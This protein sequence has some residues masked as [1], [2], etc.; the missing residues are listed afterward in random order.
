[1]TRLRFA[2]ATTGHLH[3]ASARMALVSWLFARRHKADFSLWLDDLDPERTS[4]EYM[5]SIAHDL[6]WLGLSWDETIQQST[7]L[8]RYEQAAD[9]L[10][11]SGRLYPC[12]E[13][14]DELRFKREMRIKRGQAPVYDRAMLKLTPEQRA[15]AEANG[16]RPYWRFRLTDTT[17]VWADM[18]LGQQWVKLTAVSDPIMIRADGTPMHLFTSVVDDIEAGTTH[19]LRSADQ[20][21]ATGIQIDLFSALGVNP[22]RL[23]FGHLPALTDTDGEKPSRRFD[24]ITLRSLRADGIESEAVAAYLGRLGT[25]KLP[26]PASL[27]QLA[28]SFDVSRFTQPAAHFDAG[29]LLA[30]NR[31]VLADMPFATVADRLPNGADEAFWNLLRGHLDTLP[32]ARLWWDIVAGTILPPVLEDQSGGNHAALLRAALAALPPEPWSR[33][34]LVA[35]VDS[36][37]TPDHTLRL[38]LT[39]EDHGPPLA[40]ILLLMTRPR[41]ARRL[42]FELGDDRP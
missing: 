11:A 6:R 29:G 30:L 9:R 21:T 16:K 25:A 42:G 38:A 1:M 3:V 12:F 23:N 28:A 13:N 17:I 36:L 4:P 37:E 8:D 18:V 31:R 33:D 24:K 41:A 5:Q 19:V 10:K 14:E 34:A 2:P 22:T 20:L 32:E 40:E 35:W 15:A 39:G 7:R 26:S 27:E